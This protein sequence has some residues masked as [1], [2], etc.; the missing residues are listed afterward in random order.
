MISVCM[1]MISLASFLAPVYAIPTAPANPHGAS[2]LAFRLRILA[3][4]ILEFHFSNLVHPLY[5]VYPENPID[6]PSRQNP[7]Q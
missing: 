2:P 6:E 5:D 1:A 7:F 4:Q 3:S